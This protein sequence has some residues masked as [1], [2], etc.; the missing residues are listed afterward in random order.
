MLAATAHTTEGGIRPQ[1][2]IS[3]APD[4]PGFSMVTVALPD[5]FAVS[6]KPF[7]RLKV[8]VATP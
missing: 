3:E 8:G 7:V 6:G 4:D 5:T 1:F 2:T